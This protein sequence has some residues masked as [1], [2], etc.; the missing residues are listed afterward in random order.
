MSRIVYTCLLLSGAVTAQHE[1][2]GMLQ[3]HKLQVQEDCSKGG[4]K[5]SLTNKTDA[6][7]CEAIN[8][9]CESCKSGKSPQDFCET[10]PKMNGC[11][12]YLKVC[13][14]AIS[15]E[16]ESC[17]SGKSPQEYCASNPKMNGCD[18]YLDLK[19][20]CHA[21]TASCES[22]K[23]GKSP[24]EYCVTNPKM[25]GCNLI[26]KPS[27]PGQQ[28]WSTHCPSCHSSCMSGLKMT[29]C[30]GRTS[31]FVCNGGCVCPEDKPIHGANGTCVAEAECQPDKPILIIEC[32]GNQVWSDQCPG[33]SSVCM[34]GG[35]ETMCFG[36]TGDFV[37]NGQ[38]VCPSDKPIHGKNGICVA[39][40]EIPK[41]EVCPFNQVW[42][43]QCPSCTS[44]CFQGFEQM[45]CESRMEGFVCNG[46]CVCPPDT[47]IRDQNGMC[48]ATCEKP[49][50]IVV[51]KPCRGDMIWNDCASCESFCAGSE[52]LTICSSHCEAKCDCPAGSVVLDRET[53]TCVEK[54]NCP[55]PEPFCPGD[56]VFHA[57]LSCFFNCDEFSGTGDAIG[58]CQEPA[59]RRVCA[60]PSDRPNAM[61]DGSCVAKCPAPITTTTTTTLGGPWDGCTGGKEWNECPS[62]W[63]D[64]DTL[65]G[66]VQMVCAMGCSPGC[67]CP[68]DKPVELNG[69][70]VSAKEC[71]Q[72]PQQCKGDL[73]WSECNTCQSSCNSGRVQKMCAMGCLANCGC[74]S[75]K[76]VLLDAEKG[77]CGT[78]QDGWCTK[79]VE[80][81]ECIGDLVWDDLSSCTTGCHQEGDTFH[82]L[83]RCQMP[84]QARCACPADKPILMNMTTG[85][86][87]EKCGSNDPLPA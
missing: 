84:P 60:C 32:P 44:D 7:C 76:P 27:C 77:T 37:C 50:V 42:S 8:A 55:R 10:N 80:E 5:P 85:T 73:V 56:Q 38:C 6:V 36:H 66:D 78:E 21:L 86:C 57:E 39:E 19:V 13:C 47:P 22:C 40:C 65:T 46:R 48:V 52:E 70:C 69:H 33:C 63:S 79:P 24:Q 64:C 34:Q 59:Q 82:E 18:I 31:D 3:I 67:A 71:S 14:E 41:P 30:E 1:N 58:R 15:A 17:K 25:N 83:G 87:V 61:V 68:S 72:P 12:I 26:L 74:P 51:P 45:M 43:K 54:G 28:V 75:D 81:K 23:S 29:M 11:D 62:C 53:G 49:I 16:C 20:C 35:K 2:S 4:C 9:E